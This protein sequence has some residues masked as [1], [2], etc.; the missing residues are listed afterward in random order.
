M[1]TTHPAMRC[2]LIG[3]AA[4]LAVLATAFLVWQRVGPRAVTVTTGQFPEE[5]VYVRSSDDIV[6]GGAMFRASKT[7]ARPAAVIWIHGWG[8]NFYSP[9]Y[10]MIG[11]A[12]AGRGYTTMTG[13]TRMHDLG[14]VAGYRYGNRIR[15]GGYW[16]WPPRRSGTSPRGS[17]SPRVKASNSWCWSATAPAGRRCAAT[18][19]ISRT[20]ASW[21]RYCVRRSSRRDEA[22]GP[23]STRGGQAPHGCGG[24]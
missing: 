16:G 3:I 5:L 14:N 17:T 6:N 19:L 8:T 13:N 24:R 9:T 22:N 23:Q 1:L 18:R 4:A 11:R 7:S 10:T 21:E 12:L 15:G 2:G 20:H